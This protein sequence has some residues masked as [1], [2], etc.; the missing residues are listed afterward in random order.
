MLN[1]YYGVRIWLSGD[2][3]DSLTAVHKPFRGNFCPTVG[4]CVLFLEPLLNAVITKD[5]LAFWQ[6]QGSLID[7][8]G[9]GNTKF[10]VAN[11]ARY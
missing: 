1:P 6:S 7:A 5:V 11:A 3:G 4:A 8:L 10:V 9:I 2:T